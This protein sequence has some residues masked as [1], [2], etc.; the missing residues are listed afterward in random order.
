MSLAAGSA[1][2]LSEVED[3]IGCSLAQFGWELRVRLQPDDLAGQGER[4]LNGGDRL[5]FIPLGE[6]VCEPFRKFYVLRRVY[7]GTVVLG[8]VGRDFEICRRRYLL[9][10]LQIKRESDAESVRMTDA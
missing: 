1:Q 7:Y 5:F 4:A 10:R 9:L 6:L 3:D 8:L 2:P